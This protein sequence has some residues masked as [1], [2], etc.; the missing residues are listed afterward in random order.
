MMNKSQDNDSSNCE[1]MGY[2]TH[3]N[4]IQTTIIMY[5]KPNTTYEHVTTNREFHNRRHANDGAIVGISRL[6]LPFL[7]LFPYVH[8]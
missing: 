7:D 6:C 1:N 5:F 3:G 4:C 2:E 8:P